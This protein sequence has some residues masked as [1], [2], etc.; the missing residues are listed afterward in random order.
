MSNLILCPLSRRPPLNSRTLSAGRI[1]LHLDP[2]VRR[3]LTSEAV[4]GLIYS[5]PHRLDGVEV[6]GVDEHR[7]SHNRRKHKGGDVTVIVDMIGH[8][9]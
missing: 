9:D 8:R 6:I 5:D 3:S 2:G 7:W 1:C 4:F